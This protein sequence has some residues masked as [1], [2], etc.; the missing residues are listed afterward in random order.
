MHLNMT[1][2]IGSKVQYQRHIPSLGSKHNG[3]FLKTST[4]GLMNTLLKWKPASP[5]EVRLTG[6]ASPTDTE[7]A[8]VPCFHGGNSELPKAQLSLN[9]LG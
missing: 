8:C 1:M 6:V 2:K 5:A 7:T 3:C 4:A 9:T